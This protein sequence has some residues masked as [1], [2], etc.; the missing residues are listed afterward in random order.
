MLL[1]VLLRV[2]IKKENVVCSASLLAN[3]WYEGISD[4]QYIVGLN[5]NDMYKEEVHGAP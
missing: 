3:D 4:Y 1:F 5:E 2:H